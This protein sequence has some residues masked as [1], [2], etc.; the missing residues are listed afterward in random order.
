MNQGL[1]GVPLDAGD[2]R[3]IVGHLIARSGDHRVQRLKNRILLR[4]KRAV[5][6]VIVGGASLSLQIVR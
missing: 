2:G 5:P 3:S 4:D 6:E 1:R